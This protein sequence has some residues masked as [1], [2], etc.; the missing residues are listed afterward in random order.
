MDITVA[1]KQ[2]TGPREAA[3]RISARS[4]LPVT[5]AEDA[6]SA[7]AATASG[8]ER[9]LDVLMLFVR[10]ETATLGV[11]EIAEMLHVSKAVVHRQLSAF[12]S[13]GF[14]ELDPA[15]HR[16]RLGPQ[17]LFLGLRYLSQID[18]R[19]LARETMTQLVAATNET[20]TLSIRVGDSRVY[21]DQVT[22]PRDVKMVIQL[23]RP[24]PLH[25]GASSKAMLAFMPE[26]ERDDY[27]RRQHLSALTAK[28]LTDADTLRKELAMIGERGYAL[29]FGERDA[30]A[31]AVAA[32]VFGHEGDLVGVI[33]V[34]G[35]IERFSAVADQAA[36]LLVNGV[37]QLSKRL[38]YRG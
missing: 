21:V 29:S 7:K 19:S 23:G 3:A 2:V 28:T 15:T 33:S 35:P 6:E 9:A 34:C 25:A 27:L 31:G 14:V 8:V 36:Q 38:G 4:Q 24:F 16:Y 12:R 11:T 18:V 30:G 17:I 1:R 20:A 32:P 37:Q 5:S 10:A 26:R 13:R 22:P